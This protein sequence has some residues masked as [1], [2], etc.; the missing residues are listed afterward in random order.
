MPQTQ[1][2]LEAE[3][4]ILD[5]ALDETDAALRTLLAAEDPA[6]GVYHAQDIHSLRQQKL[7]LMTRK[8]LRKVRIRRILAGM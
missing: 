7:V 3:I 6:N 1:K 4:A 5:A 2:E 8:E